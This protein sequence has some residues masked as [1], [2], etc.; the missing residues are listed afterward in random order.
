[1]QIVVCSLTKLAFLAVR[2]HVL[3]LG[4][5]CLLH[6]Q[7]GHFLLSFQSP[8]RCGVSCKTYKLLGDLSINQSN[9]Y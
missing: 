8:W 9:I 3:T 7:H 1:M 4:L 2:L 6:I 5:I